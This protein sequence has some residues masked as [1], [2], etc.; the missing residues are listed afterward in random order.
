MEKALVYALR[1]LALYERIRKIGSYFVLLAHIGSLY[2]ENGDHKNA[3]RYLRLG[4]AGNRQ[5]GKRDTEVC[6]C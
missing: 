6:P 5:A 1:A 2:E 4:V 3:L